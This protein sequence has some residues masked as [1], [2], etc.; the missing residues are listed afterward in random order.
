M[1]QQ[2][3]TLILVWKLGVAKEGCLYFVAHCTPRYLY[4]HSMDWFYHPYIYYAPIPCMNE[5]AAWLVGTFHPS[6]RG[7]HL[8]IWIDF[9]DE[10]TDLSTTLCSMISW[11]SVN[12]FLQRHFTSSQITKKMLRRESTR[13]NAK[14]SGHSGPSAIRFQTKIWYYC[15]IHTAKLPLSFW[16]GS[17]LPSICWFPWFSE[18]PC[19][20]PW[21]FTGCWGYLVWR[22]FFAGKYDDKRWLL[23]N[24]QTDR[25][26]C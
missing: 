11:N 21:G 22:T 3:G 14:F 6:R 18:T 15:T 25:I 20:G 4:L 13:K 9:T 7:M 8:P 24:P 2:G 23:F 12:Q 10:L 19:A 5:C 26:F 16:L 1:E 17:A